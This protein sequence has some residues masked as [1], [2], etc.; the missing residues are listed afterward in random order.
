MESMMRRVKINS[1]LNDPAKRRA[2]MVGVIRATQEREG[3]D[4]SLENA[5]RAYDK[6]IQEGGKKVL[7]SDKRSR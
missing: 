1:I 7:D 3:I 4:C 5:Q 6:I 2:L